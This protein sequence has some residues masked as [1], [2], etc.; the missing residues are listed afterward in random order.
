MWQSDVSS[1]YEVVAVGAL[2]G[3]FFT[4]TIPLFD[5]DRYCRLAG[6]ATH[7]SRFAFIEYADQESSAKAIGLNGTM[8]LD[9]ALKYVTM[10]ALCFL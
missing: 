6:D 2:S 1:L 7:P 9:R 8:L 4:I 10:K 3:L 5:W